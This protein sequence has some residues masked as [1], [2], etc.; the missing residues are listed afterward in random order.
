[1]HRRRFLQLVGSAAATATLSSCGTTGLIAH[2]RQR[3]RLPYGVQAGDVDATSAVIWAASDRPARMVVE[4][5]TSDTFGEVQ[6]TRERVITEWDGG[7]GDES[8]TL[9]TICRDGYVLT[10]CEPG[11]VHQGDEGELYD[12]AADP[13]QFENLWDDPARAGLKRDLLADLYDNLPPART[14]PLEQVALV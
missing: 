3:P 11:S 2:S 4:V 12:L 14:P 8:V 6:Q 7:Y 9:R 1:M 5:A 10:A 13:R